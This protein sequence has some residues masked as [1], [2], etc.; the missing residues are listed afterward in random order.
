MKDAVE[1]S[2]PQ[3]RQRAQVRVRRMTQSVAVAATASLALLGVLVAKEDPGSTSAATAQRAR[4]LVVLHY[5]NDRAH[6]GFV[7][8][9]HDERHDLDADVVD[10]SDVN[11]EVGHGDLGRYLT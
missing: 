9:E 1:R 11:H 7:V 6:V 3:S 2:S 5:G 4:R 8:L 10:N